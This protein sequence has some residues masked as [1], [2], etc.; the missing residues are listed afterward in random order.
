[1]CAAT[2]EVISQCFADRGL[3]RPMGAPQKRDGRD[4]HPVETVAALRRLLLDKGALNGVKGSVASE[5]LERGDF[6]ISHR[7]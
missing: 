4:D 3:F 2:T 1:M 6:A 7:A 5:T